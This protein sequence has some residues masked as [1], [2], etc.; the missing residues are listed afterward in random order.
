MTGFQCDGASENTSKKECVID[1][2]DFGLEA[3][4]RV[5]QGNAS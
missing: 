2:R 3:I 4:F 1:M 5:G